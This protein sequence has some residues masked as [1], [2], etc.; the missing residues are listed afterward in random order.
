LRGWQLA[1]AL[2]S[3]LW[4][5]TVFAGPY[6]SP[7]GFSIDL[8]QD[9]IVLSGKE[10][11]QN[12]DLFKAGLDALSTSMDP[13]MLRM[14]KQQI[15]SGA[16]EMYFYQ[17]DRIGKPLATVANINVNKG[18][19]QVPKTKPEVRHFC[20]EY[21]KLFE[22]VMHKKIELRAC[23]ERELPS[24][25]AIYMNSTGFREGTRT[26][27]YEIAKSFSVYITVTGTFSESVLPEMNEQFEKIVR[28]IK[29]K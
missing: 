7:F 16:M 12:P 9:W 27:Q 26:V 2:G 19:G 24:G 25:A 28:S 22:T 3:L 5:S 17:G 21:P 13:A 10:L 6:E 29:F 15:V 20:E 23:E 14:I 18:I 8:P 1:I 11:E 4:A